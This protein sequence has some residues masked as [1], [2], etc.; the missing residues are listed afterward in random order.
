MAQL[1]NSVRL[2]DMHVQMEMWFPTNMFASHFAKNWFCTSQGP[3][4][5]AKR[6]YTQPAQKQL[7]QIIAKSITWFEDN[8]SLG[9][10]AADEPLP[11]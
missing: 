3:P 6:S 5:K 7:V 2:Q 11:L 4:R 1:S 9:P 8:T 10:L